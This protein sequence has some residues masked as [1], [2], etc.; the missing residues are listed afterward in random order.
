MKL[1]SGQLKIIAATVV[2]C[3][4]FWL[5]VNVY[6]GKRAESWLQEFVAASEKSHSYRL[7]NLHH[8]RGLLSSQGYVDVALIDDCVSASRPG[9]SLIHI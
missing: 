6:A 4:L 5:G 1:S 8:Q 9:L 2:G 3:V 7:R